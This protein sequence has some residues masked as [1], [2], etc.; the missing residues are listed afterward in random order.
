MGLHLSLGTL[1]K[2]VEVL[3]KVVVYLEVPVPVCDVYW[4]GIV[5]SVNGRATESAP[6]ESGSPR[7]AGL[8]CMLMSVE[9]ARVPVVDS[10]NDPVTPSKFA[11]YILRYVVVGATRPATPAVSP[12]DL[13]RRSRP[14]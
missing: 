9:R 6:R 7:R 2:V 1:S 13:V 4:G 8:R 10:H 11:V 3:S 5:V 14:W 12:V